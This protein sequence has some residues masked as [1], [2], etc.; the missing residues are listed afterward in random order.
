MLHTHF[1]FFQLKPELLL[2]RF[3]SS[4]LISYSTAASNQN[5]L[6]FR[7][8][9]GRSEYGEI[10][11]G[12]LGNRTGHAMLSCCTVSNYIMGCLF[13]NPE[14][15]VS[16][17]QLAS[18]AKCRT[19]TSKAPVC[20][21]DLCLCESHKKTNMNAKHSEGGER[22]QSHITIASVETTSFLD[23]S[24]I[25]LAGIDFPPPLGVIQTF[26]SAYISF[27]I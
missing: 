8:E 10:E 7:G 27:Y 11:G 19:A 12:L 1:F 22:I 17:W 24:K 4:L 21:C 5:S 13:P 23:L 14:L 26:I 25:S 20:V 18:D 16:P 9:A 15:L 2:L 3:I 6:C